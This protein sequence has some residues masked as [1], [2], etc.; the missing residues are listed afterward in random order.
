M[1]RTLSIG[2]ISL[3]SIAGSAQW[4][5][6]PNGVPAFNAKPPAKGTNLPPILS[7][8]QLENF[9][10][11]VQVKA[12]QA[13]AKLPAVFHQLPCYCYCDRHAGHKSLRTCFESEHGANCSTCMKEALFAEQQTKLGK[14]PAQIRAAIIRGDFEKIDLVKLDK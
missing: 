6:Q 2:L 11:P 10:H 9:Q 5:A 12:Y 7:G 13:A 14:T 8:A 3:I 4:V 1:K